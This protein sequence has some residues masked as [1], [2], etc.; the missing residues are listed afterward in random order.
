MRAKL[1]AASMTDDTRDSRT[2]TGASAGRTRMAR[3]LGALAVSIG[4]FTFTGAAMSAPAFAETPAPSPTRSGG[5]LDDLLPPL[6]PLLPDDSES[7]SPTE[8][9]S[10]DPTESPSD[11][12]TESPTGA[13]TSIDPSNV[14][15]IERPETEQRRVDDDDLPVTGVDASMTA[16]TGAAMLGAGVAILLIARRRRDAEDEARATATTEE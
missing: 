15:T 5:L 3:R 2:D 9:P 1:R 13:P 8:P 16:G 10:D 11:D 12:P 14:E 6:P 4:L 7:P